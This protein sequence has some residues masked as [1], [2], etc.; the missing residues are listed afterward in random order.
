MIQLSRLF[1]SLSVNDGVEQEVDGAKRESE[2]HAAVCMRYDSGKK[3][4]ACRTN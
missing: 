1:Y 4:L 3:K 2:M